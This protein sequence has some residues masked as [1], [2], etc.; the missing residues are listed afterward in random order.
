MSTQIISRLLDAGERLIAPS[1]RQP[2]PTKVGALA[3]LTETLFGKQSSSW[4]LPLLRPHV[5]GVILLA[6]LT[7]SAS[8]LGLLVPYFTKM[9]IDDALLPGDFQ[10][11]LTTTGL[12]FFTGV[13]ALLAGMYNSLLHLRFSV[14]LLNDLRKS[15]LCSVLAMSPSQHAK[16][17]VGEIL[18]RVDGD[19]SQL[20]RFA[21]DALLSGGGAIV[22]LCGSV[23]F[24]LWLDWRLTLLVIAVA[25]F[26]L[27]FLVWARPGTM[28]R[29]GEVREQRG[30][31]VS[32]LSETIAAVPV[33]QSIAA[34]QTRFSHFSDHQKDLTASLIKQRIW[35]EWIGFVPAMLSASVRTGILLYGGFRVIEGE[36]GL[37]S[38]IAFLSY[39]G[40]MLGPMRSLLG[41]YHA[42]A[43]VR[44][45]I[46]RLD[47]LALMPAGLV[48]TSK[49]QSIAKGPLSIRFKDIM[50]AYPGQEHRQLMVQNLEIEHGTKLL[51]RGAS[52]LG[53]STLCRLLA[54][55]TDPSEG[56][57]FLNDQL[58]ESVELTE[59]RKRVV[60]VPQSGFLF[61]GS[62]MDNL[63]LAD[64]SLSEEDA[65]KVLDIVELSEWLKDNGGLSAPVD[66]RAMNMSGGE[67]QRLSIARALLL[68]FH[69]I[70]FDESF[71]QIDS[72]TA[73]T[74]IENIDQCYAESTRLYVAH[75]DPSIYLP[76]DQVLNIADY[77]GD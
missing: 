4:I 12:L 11:L 9:I 46:E 15:I 72:M 18:S 56:R 50:F 60:L 35:T 49:T 5:R 58:I 67:K 36:I 28:S 10:R 40:F 74:I 29:A 6:V 20:Q 52:G 41:I 70:V 65:W 59:L 77:I 25:P 23:G 62:V 66:E 69:I 27:L 76:C 61:H 2:A 7:T 54:R 30:R 1:A 34:T 32:M 44:A 75:A 26:E 51:L 42:Q 39:L 64:S 31:M 45:S 73:K 68:P 13:L 48:Q 33:L 43:R 53:K 37:G 16:Q 24:M 57:I 55:Y 22:R 14:Q 17:R 47:L 38:L 3:R 8:L 21:F 63:R 19:A 71:S